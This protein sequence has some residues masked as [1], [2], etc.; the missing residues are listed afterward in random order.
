ML[1]VAERLVWD[2]VLV[3]VGGRRGREKTWPRG[4]W[5]RHLDFGF[6]EFPSIDL[7]VV[8]CG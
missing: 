5:V 2:Q 4:S 3:P 7:E 6:V 8:Q 1:Y